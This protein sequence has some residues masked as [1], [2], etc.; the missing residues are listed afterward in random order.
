MKLVSGLLVIMLVGSVGCANLKPCANNGAV[1]L[2][3][4][5]NPAPEESSSIGWILGGLVAA[6]G[7][8]MVGENNDWWSG[9]DKDDKST[10]PVASTQV[11]GDQTIII[12]NGDG[13]RI[14]FKD[15]SYNG[16]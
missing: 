7:I 2:A 13:N 5:S 12:V 6:G 8:Y 14:D 9:S 16:M 15:D 3:Y 4:C 1:G 11:R 10:A